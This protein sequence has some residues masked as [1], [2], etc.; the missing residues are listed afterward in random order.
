MDICTYVN[1]VEN[2]KLFCEKCNRKYTLYERKHVCGTLKC[3]KEDTETY[4]EEYEPDVKRDRFMI[5]VVCEECE[6]AHRRLTEPRQGVCPGCNFVGWYVQDDTGLCVGCIENA[7]KTAT[8][9]PTPSDPNTPS[10]RPVRAHRAAPVEKIIVKPDLFI[11]ARVTTNVWDSAPELGPS[12]VRAWKCNSVTIT[13]RTLESIDD[14]DDV[15]FFTIEHDRNES[16]KDFHDRVSRRV[17]GLLDRF[18]LSHNICWRA[19][20]EA[21][22]FLTHIAR[23]RGV[24]FR[25]EM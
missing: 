5:V 24:N 25:L 13:V 17:M 3:P 20:F 21:A 4:F 2:S 19:D 22:S 18:G 16:V 9:T 6:E 1:S 14:F 8:S 11:R 23:A 15:D 10:S 7:R 12:H